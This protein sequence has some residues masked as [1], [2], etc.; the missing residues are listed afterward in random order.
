M[1][2]ESKV[3]VAQ[4]VKAG[5]LE[6]NEAIVMHRRDKGPTPRATVLE[7]GT[8]RLSTGMRYRTPSAAACAAVDVG[9]IDGWTRWRVPR[10][11]NE[12]LDSVRKRF[13]E[14]MRIPVYRGREPA[15]EPNPKAFL[16]QND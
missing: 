6:V 16:R 3:S 8:I 7:D 13:Q 15:D 9:S 11:N 4:L 12:T 10:L 5:L 2:S 14:P 1:V